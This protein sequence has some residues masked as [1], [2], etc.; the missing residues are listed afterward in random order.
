L[1]VFSLP[2]EPSFGIFASPFGSSAKLLEYHFPSSPGEGFVSMKRDWSAD[3]LAEHW[4]LL[5]SEQAL[6][7]NKSGATRLGFAVLLK[8]FQ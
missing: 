6:L 2:G 4:T 8:F 5:P 1:R 7:S 3:E